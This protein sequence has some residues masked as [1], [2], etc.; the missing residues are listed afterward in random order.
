MNDRVSVAT[1]ASTCDQPL[2][3]PLNTGTANIAVFNS[4]NELEKTVLKAGA[5]SQVRGGSFRGTG[6]SVQVN[7]LICRQPLHS[8]QPTLFVHLSPSLFLIPWPL[9]AQ[10]LRFLPNLLH[11]SR[12]ELFAGLC[13]ATG[14]R[15]P[16]A[17]VPTP[18]LY[19][20]V[21]SS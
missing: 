13:R 3:Y 11:H 2:T 17:V 8:H 16:T 20:L 9:C 10:R 18:A 4:K 6:G 21:P 15:A 5:Q 14:G 12:P 19:R 1:A 7:R